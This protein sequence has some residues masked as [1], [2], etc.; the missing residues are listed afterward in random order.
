MVLI[1]VRPACVSASLLT[2][3]LANAELPKM[4][5]NFLITTGM[6]LYDC[7]FVSGSVCVC[8]CVCVSVCE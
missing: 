5:N 3:Y 6:C 8:V 4:R 1:L 7:V 2:V